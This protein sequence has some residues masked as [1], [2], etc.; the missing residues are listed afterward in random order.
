MLVRA[1]R[2]RLVATLPNQV[3]PYACRACPGSMGTA[4]RPSSASLAHLASISTKA[5]EL[6]AC[7]APSAAMDRIHS[8]VEVLAQAHASLAQQASI[9]TR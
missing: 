3:D 1:L 9:T 8:V 2:V 7:R 4:R 6:S 5:H